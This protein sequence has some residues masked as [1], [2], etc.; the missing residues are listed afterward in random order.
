MHLE[1]LAGMEQGP[2]GW[3]RLKV[4]NNSIP[5]LYSVKAIKA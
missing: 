5:L 4:E 1:L 3:W 2:D